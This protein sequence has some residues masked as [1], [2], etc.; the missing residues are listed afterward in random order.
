MLICVCLRVCV[1]AGPTPGLLEVIPEAVTLAQI[2]Q[3]WG[4]R[5]PLREDTLEK[6]FHMWNRTEEEYEKVRAP[7]PVQT[8]IGTAAEQKAKE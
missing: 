8:A 4:L 2:Q 1:H 7:F 3:E 5:G 6:W